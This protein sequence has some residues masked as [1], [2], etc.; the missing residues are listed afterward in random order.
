MTDPRHALGERAELAVATW[1]S[2]LGWRVLERRW[3]GPAGELDLVCVD[4]GGVL[5]GVE[6]KVR[7][8]DRAG[9]GLESV[10]R[11]RLGR[12]RA[13]LAAFA[14]ARVVAHQGA[15]LDLVTLTPADDGKWRIQRL[16]AIDAW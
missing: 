5:V 6:V 16:P 4:P 8:T 9:S 1:L 2:T 10:E 14:T 11:R 3:R 7:R 12:L 13:T 15:R